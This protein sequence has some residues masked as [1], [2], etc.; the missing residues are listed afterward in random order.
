MTTGFKAERT[1]VDGKQDEY[2]ERGAAKL[3]AEISAMEDTTR[4]EFKAETDVNTIVKKFGLQSHREV[5]QYL[6]T[7]FGMD[8]QEAIRIQ[9]ETA[10][11]FRRL[12]K[13]L[14]RDYPSWEKVLEAIAKGE[15]RIKTPDDPED[16][17]NAA[18][19]RAIKIDDAKTARQREKRAQE[20][21]ER[22]RREPDDPAPSK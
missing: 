14:Q 19:E 17:E 3:S 10:A 12:P 16:L 15:I 6:E 21:A 11:A 2:S 1:Q 22:A 20:A 18:I 5:P 7:D 9:E 4:Q 13:D 8:L